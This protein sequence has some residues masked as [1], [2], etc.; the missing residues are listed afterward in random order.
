[1]S[2]VISDDTALA[3]TGICL[4]GKTLDAAQERATAWLAEVTAS[5]QALALNSSPTVQFAGSPFCR[6]EAPCGAVVEY[7][8]AADFPRTDVPCPCGS[9]KHRIVH[10]YATEFAS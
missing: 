3:W 8:T 5:E 1:M 4:V 6:L 10:Y 2:D 7:R 9:P